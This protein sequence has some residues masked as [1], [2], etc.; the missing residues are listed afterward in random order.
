MLSRRTCL[1]SVPLVLAAGWGIQGRAGAVPAAVDDGLPPQ[2]PALVSAPVPRAG[3]DQLSATPAAAAV[4]AFTADVY[5]ALA[6]RTRGNLVCSP[7]SVLTAL[8]M[9]R[10]GARGTTAAEMDA[11]LHAPDPVPTA[12]HAGLNALDQLIAAGSRLPGADG[13]A[14]AVTL[15][16]ANSLWGQRGLAWEQEFLDLLGRFYGAGMHTVDYRTAT[17]TARRSINDWVGEVTA[18]RIPELVPVG[19][20]SADSSLTLVN[21]IHLVAR[22]RTVFPVAGTEP[23]T[24]TRSDSSTLTVPMMASPAQPAG[25][26]SGT[27]WQAVDIPY[28]GGE[29]AMAVVVPDQGLLPQVEAGADAVWWTSVLSGFTTEQIRVRLP[30]WTFRV[31][32]AM[33]S[34]LAELGM[35][36]AFSDRADFSA[37]TR[38]E[39]LA[40]DAVIH[41]AFINVDEHGTEAAA[42]TAVVMTRSVTAV[43]SARLVAVDR[44]FLFAVHD[45]ATGTP[46][47]VGRVTEPS[48]G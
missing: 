31:N 38:D 8:A 23:G 28:A 13:S 12:L 37:M 1:S 27:G 9:T 5:R 26:Q 2:D 15:R 48:T 44:P 18:G 45:L 10:A 47:F 4:R 16:G 17:E 25:Y 24:F 22:W 11:V 6:D 21:A 39:H 46:L 14:P 35:P 29:L 7:Y 36:T 42:A 3:I 34:L 40:I 32:V 19:V 20:L 33:Q 43:T 41:E 30:R